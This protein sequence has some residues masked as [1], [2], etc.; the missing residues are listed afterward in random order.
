[1]LSSS[2]F[3]EANHASI[4]TDAITTLCKAAGDPL[5]M[6]ILRVLQQNS[7]GVLELCEV[8]GIRQSAMSHHLKILANAS[9]VA[10]RREG[11]SIFYRRNELNPDIDLQ[12][13]QTSLFETIDNAALDLNYT[14]RLALIN[15]ARSAASVSFFNRNADRFEDNQDL[16]AGWDDY[17]ESIQS[18]MP[19]NQTNSNTALEV[20]PGFGQFLGMLSK[21]FKRVTA[22]DSS[23]EM[24]EQS[25]KQAATQRLNNIEFILG[26]TNKVVL[27]KTRYDF[28]SINMVLHHNATPADLI[29]DCAKL[30]TPN[31]TM[32]VTELCEHGQ[33]W[34]KASCGDIWL[35]FSPESLTR[36]A[37]SAGLVDSNSIYI[38]QRNGFRIQIRQF[39][40]A[41]S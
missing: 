23:I 34:V 11:T 24:L 31:G 37:S 13:L 28:I 18:F 20:G 9:L 39:N 26:D 5:R 16:I 25:K 3:K 12:T 36:W 35:G 33:E 29:S 14:N 2:A 10:T 6:Q 40:L 19:K 8:F 30:L 4:D 17:G 15:K 22:L 7:Y 38:A 32:M 1:M 27:N 21:Q 41:N